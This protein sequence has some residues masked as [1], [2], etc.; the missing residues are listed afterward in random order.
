MNIPTMRHLIS[1]ATLFVLA[2]VAVA[3]LL[4]GCERKHEDQPATGAA[5]AAP[6]ITN[7]VDINASVRQN[8]GI[9]F[10][11]V[12]SRQVART[13]RV[14]GRF[15]LIP[16][17][18]REYR[19][20]APGT[21]ELLV[22]Q[23]QTVGTGTPLYRLDSPR[24]RE[25]QRELADA[26]A[27][28]KIAQAANDSIAPLLAA[29]ETHHN[30]IQKAVDLWTAR[31]TSLDELMSAGGAR[32]EEVAQARAAMASAR[33]DLAETLETEAELLAR[34]S[35]SAASLDA[36]R[37][38]LAFLSEAAASLAGMSANELHA[39]SLTDPA[40]PRW[41]T[42]TGIE[43][44][45]ITPG[46]VEGVGIV[47]GGVIDQHAAALSTVQPELVRFRAVGLQSDL[48]RLTDGQRASVVPAQANAGS[49]GGETIAPLAPLSGT[50]TLA[51][52][53]DPER[54]TVELIFTA[55][56][57][58]PSP[59]WARAGVS[60]F[61]E[62]V[63]SGTGGAGG[64]DDLAIPLKCVARDGTQAIIFRRD[65][66]DPNKAI[67]MDADLGLDDGRWVVIKSGVAEGNEIVLD[68]VY[69]LMVATSGSI[70]KGGHFHPDGTFHEGSE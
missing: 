50:L 33:S 58:S 54:R 6:A 69:Q 70:T 45:A 67:R 25:M 35:Q 60:A 9:T 51:P 62:V 59:A 61:L 38:R 19:A 23:Y 34:R 65:P 18:R 68:G 10:A 5:P 1:G 26:E 15:E 11:K 20:I 28:V 52:T 12:E 41:R 17:A 30:E 24:W 4:L 64:G 66:A 40:L 3:I 7:R 29:H 57:G 2:T 49:G 42:L 32:G 39:P 16:T 8:L 53:A 27:S 21:V 48:P 47:S 14:P 22:E 43:V 37:S 36:A 13:L 46:V 31:V 44:R 56:D 55:A 63:T